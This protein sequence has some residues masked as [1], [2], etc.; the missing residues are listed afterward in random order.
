MNLMDNKEFIPVKKTLLL[1][2]DELGIYTDN[3]EGV[4]FGQKLPNGH[5]TLVFVAD[6][7]FTILQRSQVLVFEILE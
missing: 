7:N 5:R 1:N 3:I 2:M 4:T 6:D